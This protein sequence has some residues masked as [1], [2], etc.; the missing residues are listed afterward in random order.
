MEDVE[1]VLEVLHNSITE[2]SYNIRF[3]KQWKQLEKILLAKNLSQEEK[4]LNDQ[5][6]S[7]AKRR[8]A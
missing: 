1:Q 4:E 8:S 6:A 2:L 3:L 5:G 7:W